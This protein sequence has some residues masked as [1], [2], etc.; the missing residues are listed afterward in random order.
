MESSVNIIDILHFELQILSAKEKE[1]WNNFFVIFLVLKLSYFSF[2]STGFNFHI[3]KGS[4][5]E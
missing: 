1:D 3:T 4:V 2:A 5:A